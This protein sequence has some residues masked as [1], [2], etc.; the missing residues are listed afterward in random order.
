MRRTAAEYAEAA[1]QAGWDGFFVWEPVYGWDAWVMLTAAAMRTQRIRLGTMITPLSRMR[2]WKLASETAHARPP[3]RRPRDADGG[4]RGAGRRASRRSARRSID[5][6]ALN[7]ST[8]LSRSSRTLGRGAVRVSRA[9]TISVEGDLLHT[10]AAPVQQPR[11][12]IWVV[13]AWPFEKSM[14]RAICVTTGSCRARAET[15]ATSGRRRPTKWRRCAAGS[16]SGE[17]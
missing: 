3:V 4:A 10:T 9:S 13:G 12:P 5:G 11:I 15:T 2:P 16:P 1:E 7:Y 14:A 8:K 6:R 17:T